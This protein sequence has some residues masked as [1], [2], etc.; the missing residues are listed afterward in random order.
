MQLIIG[1]IDVVSPVSGPH[2]DGVGDGPLG[3][4]W[5]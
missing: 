4:A 2:Q 3:V 5:E 1:D